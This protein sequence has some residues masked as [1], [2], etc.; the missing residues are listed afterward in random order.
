MVYRSPEEFKDAW[1]QDA[2]DNYE[3]DAEDQDEP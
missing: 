2:I 3:L 1:E